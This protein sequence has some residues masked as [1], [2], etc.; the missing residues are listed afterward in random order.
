LRWDSIGFDW[1]WKNPIMSE[2]DQKFPTLSD[3]VSPF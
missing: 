2:R 3:F 1:P